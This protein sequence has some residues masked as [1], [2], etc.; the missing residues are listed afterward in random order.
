MCALQL[1][2]HIDSTDITSIPL[3]V[4]SLN[5]SGSSNRLSFGNKTHFGGFKVF[6]LKLKLLVSSSK[7]WF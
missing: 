2:L 1:I 7:F 4:S 6:V 5:I 3:P